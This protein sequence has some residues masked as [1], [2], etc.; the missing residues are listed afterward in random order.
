MQRIVNFL[1]FLI[2]VIETSL[3][4]SITL[5]SIFSD[6][7][8]LQQNSN[9][10]I[11]GWAK[12]REKITI[13]SSWDN[14]PVVTT[15]DN[16]A[17]WQTVIKTPSAGGPHTLTFIGSNTIILKDI[18][19]GEVWLCS[20]QSNM[21][22]SA[23][24]GIDNGTQEVLE[25]NYSAIR[26]F[27]VTQ[28]AAQSRQLDCDGTW[29]ICSPQTMIDFSAV[30]Y[31]FGKQLY[32]NLNIPIGL[33]NS[34]WGGTPAETWINPNIIIENTCYA[35]AAKKIKEMPWCPEKP[36]ETYFS[37]IAPLVPFPIA[38]VIWYQGETNTNNFEIYSTL[39][40]ALIN[41]WRQE[42]GKDFPFYYVQ[43]APY[44]Y[45][46]PEIGVK[47]REAQRK[48]L[49]TPHTGMVVISDIGDI[50]DIHPR[51]K[52]DVGERLANWA[53]ARTYGQEEVAYSGPLY[54]EKKIEGNKIRIFF[55]YAENGLICRGENLTHFEIAGENKVYVPAEAKIDGHTVTVRA[56]SIKNPLAVR[57][58][59]DN[60]AEPNLFNAEGLPA[61]CFCTDN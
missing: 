25:A 57:F 54:R 22:W 1:L 56:Q 51:N 39:F 36:G 58:A 41:N 34:S 49:A 30:G 9:L 19:V 29:S 7:M 46:E 3:S 4:A 60:I 8:V 21:E 27:Q 33:I 40:P 45:G 24:L 23:R 55:D 14:N 20:G 44:K 61:S 32:N 15:A 2:L 35:Q 10:H 17:D 11:W 12:P 26:F 5:P 16:H 31:F 59:W 6:H 47:I 18:L 37:M 43:I 28:K 48:S 13:I 38:G 52:I 53:L 50:N 42:W